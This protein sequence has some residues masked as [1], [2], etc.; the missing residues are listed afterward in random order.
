MYKRQIEDQLIDIKLHHSSKIDE[1]RRALSN[2]IGGKVIS[3]WR[4]RNVALVGAIQMEKIG[5]VVVLSLILLVAS[6]SILSTIYLMT[7]R[8]IKDFGVLRFLGMKMND[9]HRL[10][11]YQALII[12]FRGFCI[13]FIS[14]VSIVLFQNIFKVISLPND[15]YAMEVLPCLLYTSPSPRDYAASRMPSSA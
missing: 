8:K 14:G 5:T 7:I 9:I 11:M 13:G 4:D 2:I 10:I 1:T 6:F 12:G 15:I 3:S